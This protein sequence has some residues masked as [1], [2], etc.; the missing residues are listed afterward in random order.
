MPKISVIIPVY[1]VEQYLERCLDSVAGQ[2]LKDIEIICINDG[3]TD[4]SLKILENYAA[5]DNR[6]KVIN[7]ENKGAAVARNAGLEIAAGEYLGFVD[8]DD[9]IDLNF[10]D[11]LYNLAKDENADIAKGN[12]FRANLDRNTYIEPLNEA[13][14]KNKFAFKHDWW[15]AIY[16]A[17]MIFENNINFPPECI[18]G[19]DGVFLIG[20]VLN[21]NKIVLNDNTFYHYYRR[22]GSL[23]SDKISLKSIKS[24]LMAKSLI[25]EYLNNSAL[26]NENP[27]DYLYAYNIRLDS[28]FY[29]FFQNNT[30]KAQCLCLDVIIKYFFECKD[31]K[32]LKKCFRYK[33][34]LPYILRKDTEIFYEFMKNNY[35]TLKE[36]NSREPNFAEKIFSIRNE[37][38]L[39]YRY[40]TVY[41]LGIKL[42]FRKKENK[43]Q[44]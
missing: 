3:S 22:T 17:S 40:K 24:A 34:V 36:F 4:G 16:K 32:S 26:F 18:K 31:V 25:L 6:I 41:I 43:C 44:K 21:A 12:C 37:V 33:C 2:T 1:N 23:D 14:H 28:I 39:G 38:S 42:K 8:P 15:S 5:K 11:V 35:I 10:Y 19:Q 29:N 9:N 30:K 13:I 7:Q 27:K 20:A